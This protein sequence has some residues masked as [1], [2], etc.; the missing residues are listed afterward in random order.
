MYKKLSSARFLPAGL[1]KSMRFDLMQYIL[2][3]VF[4]IH[5][6]ILVAIIILIIL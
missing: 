4:H 1:A 3:S 6:K 2:V 5:N